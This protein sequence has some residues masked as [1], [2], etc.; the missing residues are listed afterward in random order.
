MNRVV[1]EKAAIEGTS[2]G[3]LA[4]VAVAPFVE[5]DKAAAIGAI[6]TLL[7]GAWKAYRA[8]RRFKDGRKQKRRATDVGR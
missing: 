3:A 8:H 6:V 5:A 4:T 2:A 7:S 1:L